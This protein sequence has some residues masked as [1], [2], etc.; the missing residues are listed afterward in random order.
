MRLYLALRRQTLGEDLVLNAANDHSVE[1]GTI[2]YLMAAE[3]I[4]A[5]DIDWLSL[6]TN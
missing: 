3:R 6:S 5:T 4:E 2:L 1:S